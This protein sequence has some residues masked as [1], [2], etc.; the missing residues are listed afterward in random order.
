MLGDGQDDN[1][2][3]QWQIDLKSGV[4][5][6][7]R[8]IKDNS[9]QFTKTNLLLVVPF[10]MLAVLLRLGNLF[11]L[12]VAL[13][14][15]IEP[16]LSPW[17]RWSVIF[18]FLVYMVVHVIK[19]LLDERQLRV[20]GKTYN[21]L[22]TRRQNNKGEFD[23]IKWK[24]LKPGDLVQL[25]NNEACPADI[26]ILDTSLPK[27]R[28]TICW[29][30]TQGIDGFTTYTL[31]KAVQTT[32]INNKKTDFNA[33][34]RIL[35]GKIEYEPPSSS[36]THCYGY[37]RL[38]KDPRAEQIGIENM[39]LRGSV[40]KNTEWVFGIV[41]YTGHDCRLM[42]NA[43]YIK[44]KR[45]Y[46]EKFVERLYLYGIAMVLILSAIST[47]TL[48]A[49][50]EDPLIE[51]VE[52]H[53]NGLKFFYNI[54]LYSPLVPISFYVTFDII[55]IIQRRLL[56][57]L[58]KDG[59]QQ[60]TVFE[61]KVFPNLGQVD[62]CFLDKTGTITTGNYKIK[63]IL[64]GG[65][66]YQ[67]DSDTLK[68]RLPEFLQSKDKNINRLASEFKYY[69]DGLTLKVD[70]SVLSGRDPNHDESSRAEEKPLKSPDAKN[71]IG[72]K[73]SQ[74][75]KGHNGFAGSLNSPHNHTEDPLIKKEDSPE[76]KISSHSDS[77][78]S[79]EE[80][81]KYKL[82]T[83]NRTVTYGWTPRHPSRNMQIQ[84]PY[85]REKSELI[86]EDPEGKSRD[87]TIPEF[88]EKFDKEKM[89]QGIKIERAPVTIN[90]TEPEKEKSDKTPTNPAL[91]NENVTVDTPQKA[92]PKGLHNV[93]AKSD[94]GQKIEKYDFEQSPKADDKVL[95]IGDAVNLGE[96]SPN[97][98]K[99]PHPES[100]I[101]SDASFYTDT[102]V[103][104]KLPAA[105]GADLRLQ[106]F[107]NS[108]SNR[109]RNS[110][111]ILKRPEPDS[112]D[113]PKG[114][115]GIGA[116]AQNPADI[117]AL[118][119]DSMSFEHEVDKICTDADFLM[120]YY[121]REE[122]YLEE[123]I[124]SL[125]I[126]H[127]AKSIG[128]GGPDATYET[129]APD[130]Y[131]LVKF[132]DLL[133]KEFVMSN[134][135]DN[136]D[137][138]LIK[139]KGERKKVE[140]LGVNDW[141]YDRKRFSIVYRKDQEKAIVCC[142][143]PVLS[144]KNSL[145]LDELE[146]EQFERAVNLWQDLGWKV[147]VIAKKEIELEEANEYSRKYQNFKMSLYD[148]DGDLEDLAKGLEKELRL[149]GVIALQDYL[150]DDS[151]ETIKFL[152][153]ADIKTWLVTGDNRENALN[154]AHLTGVVDLDHDIHHIKL[155]HQKSS[156]EKEGY[157]Q[158]ARGVIRTILNRIKKAYL[159]ENPAGIS[160][161][162]INKRIRKSFT[163]KSVYDE[164]RYHFAVSI[165]GPS[166][167]KI[168]R[169]PYL[170]ANFEFICAMC[171]A[172]VGYML[173]PKQKELLVNMVKTQFPNNPITMAIGDGLNDAL[174]LE[175]ADV[176]IEIERRNGLLASNSGDF[177]LSN[178][179]MLKDLLLVRGRNI[180]MNIDSIIYFT[181]FKSYSFGLMLFMYNFYTK[182]T[183]AP[184]FD[185]MFV[186]MYTFI[187]T[188]IPLIF[189]G[190]NNKTE[191]TL[192]LKE[193]PALYIDG[194]NKKAIA[195]KIFLIKAVFESI[196][197]AA[198]IFFF[199][200]YVCKGGTGPNGEYISS[201]MVSLIMF[202]SS[203]F[204]SNAKLFFHYREKSWSSVLGIIISFV[205]LI[206]YI[207]VNDYAQ[208]VDNRYMAETDHV[209]RWPLT[210]FC[211]IFTSFAP[212]AISYLI[213]HEF[214]QKHY[215]SS[216]DSFAAMRMNP[217]AGSISNEEILIR[218][219]G[220]LELG[221]TVRSVYK[222]QPDLMDPLVYDMLS[223]ADRNAA[224]IGIDKIT[225]KFLDRKL[226]R[227][228]IITSINQMW[229][230][231]RIVYFGLLLYF[232]AYIIGEA[233]QEYKAAYILSRIGVFVVFLVYGLFL[234]LN[235]FRQRFHILT[236]IF[237][238]AALIAKLVY[239]WVQKEDTSYSA[240]LVPVVIST[241]L[242]ISAF[243]GA[244]LNV[245]HYIVWIIRIIILYTGDNFKNGLDGSSLQTV[246]VIASYILLEL[247]IT[248]LMA[249]LGYR[250]ET[251]KRVD[252]SANTQIAQQVNV[253]Q[254][255]LSILLPKFI[256]DKIDP[257]VGDDRHVAEDQGEVA[258]LFC[259]IMDFDKVVEKEGV[260]VAK[261]LDDVFRAF[262]QYSASHGIQKIE[263][264]GKTYMGCGGLKDCEMVIPKALAAM[265]PIRRILNL[266]LDMDDFVH[267]TT[268]GNG[269]QMK[270]RIGIHFGKVIAGVIGY[271]KP[272]FSLI[273]DTVN[274]TS[275]VCTSNNNG[276]IR[277]SDDAFRKLSEAG[278]AGRL[279]IDFV[280]TKEEMKGKGMVTVHIV[281][282]TS[283]NAVIK[284][285]M[286][287]LKK[288]QVSAKLSTAL[289]GH[290]N[291]QGLLNGLSSMA[292][293]ANAAN[294][295]NGNANGA[296]AHTAESEDKK[297]LPV[298]ASSQRKKTVAELNT[299]KLR[300]IKKKKTEKIK[301]SANEALKNLSVSMKK[302]FNTNQAIELEVPKKENDDS[303]SRNLSKEFIHLPSDNHLK[304]N[305]NSNPNSKANVPKNPSRMS[306]NTNAQRDKERSA[307]Y[308]KSNA[309]MDEDHDDDEKVHNDE[310]LNVIYQSRKLL[311]L[312]G[313]PKK[314]VAQFLEYVYLK[315]K[316]FHRISLIIF[317]IIYIVQSAL[318]ISTSSYFDSPTVIIVLRFIFLTLLALYYYFVQIRKTRS[319][320]KL[321]STAALTMGIVATVTQGCLSTSAVY[322]RIQVVELLYIYLLITYSTH[323]DFLWNLGMSL[324]T[325]LCFFIGY[326][327]SDNL[328]LD[329]VYFIILFIFCNLPQVHSYISNTVKFYNSYQKREKK[330]IEQSTLVGQLLPPHA[331]E[332]LT[333]DVGRFELGD[334]FH[335]VTI[336]YADIKGFTDYSASVEPK[337]VVKMLSSLFTK[338]D[339]SCMEQGLYKVYTIG[340][341]YVVLSFIDANNRD[342]GM[343]AIKVVRLALDMIS[344]IRA[345]RKEIEF[346]GLDMRI[347]LHTGTVIGGIVGTE[348]VRYDI[349][350]KDCIIA[351]NMESHGEKGNINVSE[352]TKNLLELTLPGYFRFE[353]REK[354][355]LEKI[356][357]QINSYLLY[358]TGKV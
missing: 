126:C 189:F 123:L 103:K 342:P 211:L 110:V 42:M 120:D 44:Y 107:I 29:L 56:Q 2:V 132:G 36:V 187:F 88:K 245:V 215:P 313:N 188:F 358:E 49:S 122:N 99:A 31:K 163:A 112:S 347:G 346:D 246:Y 273:G 174:M 292:N 68:A 27:N 218:N 24:D 151:V 102:I 336:L 98:L 157:K 224:N 265:N 83:T 158:D 19:D 334:I 50:R 58:K 146:I 351:N 90:K 290:S 41:L 341:C 82:P 227:R 286:H 343:E 302:L 282:K 30:D 176:G 195:W 37:I 186:F 332:K 226:E 306:V 247:G 253:S 264:V 150:K 300:D 309:N 168:F 276:Q 314:K 26:L 344:I 70:D 239:D 308:I 225:L 141:S 10:S 32:K 356:S 293:G 307:S 74:F 135:T 287:A 297:G 235:T 76:S 39:I 328:T 304:E 134:K 333:N 331:L 77:D 312:K 179:G 152:K 243:R 67:I 219:A 299:P 316:K 275:R 159:G 161:D 54:V 251:E 250:M 254:G 57:N 311:S 125:A 18:P 108:N 115:K 205:C 12:A 66:Q 220:K 28:G 22:K 53:L 131:A 96:N 340:D 190:V 213:T 114:K 78:H 177:K 94:N 48:A 206:I 259:D 129:V 217:E 255:I 128:F 86:I 352:T 116:S 323:I 335:D 155:D 252:F 117:N 87:L 303:A 34:R 95:H 325:V 305:S 229:R 124:D 216:Y 60:A 318:M 43:N 284:K 109:R 258:I 59:R 193:Y 147:I 80:R 339:K 156:D 71:H 271:H 38:K 210:L 52:N 91:D 266:A 85:N 40:L 349:W 357:T 9:V 260:K 207:V 257:L 4:P 244:A 65:K 23:D 298:V 171:Y 240:A 231:V 353:F 315:T 330:K 127:S 33:Y 279:D 119:S 121:N 248:S 64:A 166:L 84:V 197:I 291:P 322:A 338:F 148:Q 81:D 198:L 133:G 97:S 143:G 230:R 320:M 61:S 113:I 72:A 17:Q 47:G 319:N 222:N 182:S 11:F 321:L 317:F 173:T 269:V 289:G 232:A 355:I 270:I 199:T 212:S 6:I 185:S 180:S 167:E 221:N 142:K 202:Y 201:G 294:G 204:L 310:D 55:L 285:N 277:I 278:G 175:T 93:Q 236:L 144:M 237:M 79:D 249:I 140:I 154:A 13:I 145:L 263:T 149:V 170:K 136:P 228:Y 208:F 164:H 111:D 214:I 169:D 209:F 25:K 153:D 196:A 301:N 288:L 162:Q 184:L 5:T 262:D 261:I 7:Y 14:M 326:G 283:S 46:F 1:Y 241:L 21:E 106:K 295:A 194:K 354:V 62:Y 268:Y 203:V 138:Y 35:T 130:E 73:P 274:T 234:I 118:I 324:V 105:A 75:N 223:P 8:D 172:L 192:V 191:P 3:E 20:Q 183:G 63:G 92:N 281:T 45:S 137:E 69:N 181:F 233:I 329:N 280:E 15:L 101:K 89:E 337:K 242:N 267:R 16:S 100:F 345:V 348:V 160:K 256:I 139:D 104:R 51:P 165:D 296:T 327:I 272:Q 200:V 238:V 350:G 178:L